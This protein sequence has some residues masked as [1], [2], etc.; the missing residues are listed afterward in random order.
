VTRLLRWDI[1]PKTER[2]AD[3]HPIQIG[4]ERPAPQAAGFCTDALRWNDRVVKP[5]PP[6]RLYSNPDQ[7]V[8]FF[9]EGLYTQGLA[10]V[11]SWG[12]MGRRSN[13][14]YGP[15]TGSGERSLATIQQIERTL[16]DAAKSIQASQ[17][18][19]DAWGMLRC[20]EAVHW[21]AVITS[22]TLHFLSRS[23]GFEQNPPVAIDGAVIRN[24]LWP[25]FSRS[26]T[27]KDRPDGWKCDSF[28]AYCRYMTAIIIWANQRNWTTTQME[29]T[30][31]DQICSLSF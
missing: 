8:R 30:I 20:M 29:A 27:R 5:W 12:G 13:A 10:M 24:K 15:K 19:E 26:M 25:K 14:I 28:Q 22:K 4:L 2:A 9:K 23:L 3:A 11:V 18:I 17:S 7:I 16:K 1:D 31:F 6:G 21:S